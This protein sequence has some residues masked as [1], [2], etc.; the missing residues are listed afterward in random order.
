MSNILTKIPTVIQ[1]A[2]E[3]QKRARAELDPFIGVKFLPQ[4]LGQIEGR[5]AEMF[6]R[7]VQEQIITSF[8]GI[9]VVVDPTDPTAVIVTAFYV[10]VFPLL[11]VQITFRVSVQTP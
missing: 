3:M 6:K 5:L 8:T 10:P 7:S 11:Y 4:I 2:D 9:S 1:I